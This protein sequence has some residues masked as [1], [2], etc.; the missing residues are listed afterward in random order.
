MPIRRKLE[1]AVPILLGLLSE[2]GTKG[3]NTQ[4]PPVSNTPD[5][6]ALLKQIR[7]YFENRQDLF[8]DLKRTEDKLLEN[9]TA[10]EEEIDN[11][12]YGSDGSRGEHSLSDRFKSI[13][14]DVSEFERLE[15]KKSEESPKNNESEAQ[16]MEI[17]KKWSELKVEHDI[18]NDSVLS[19]FQLSYDNIMDIDVTG[20]DGK[21]HLIPGRNIK[22]CLLCFSV[23]PPKSVI[24]KRPLIYWWLGEGLI[25]ETEDG[26]RIFGE[27]IKKGLLIAKYKPN[28]QD[29]NPIVDSCTM[30][31]W[32][33]LMLI[34]VAKRA[35]FFDFDDDTGLPANH[36]TSSRRMCLVKQ[37]LNKQT[38]PNGE[39]SRQDHTQQH[40]NSSSRAASTEH[41]LLTLFNVNEQY[42]NISNI[43]GFSEENKI[44]VLQLGRW[45]DSAKHHIEVENEDFLKALGSKKHL[46]Y[47]SLRGI[48]RITEI[49]SSLR[50]L[51]NLEILDLRA[52]H[53]LEK[54]PSDISA[55][56]KLTHLDISECHLLESMPKGLEEL[57]SLQVLKGFVVATSKRSPCKLEK[58]AVLDQLR[59]LSIY[60]RNEAYME[61]LDKLRKFSKLRIL[62][63]TWGERGAQGPK[64]QPGKQATESKPFPFPPKLE[65]LDLWCIPETDPAWLDPGELLSLR[66]LYIRGGKLVSFKESN[67]GKKWEVQILRLKYLRAFDENKPWRRNFPYLCY[68][69]I[70]KKAEDEHRASSSRSN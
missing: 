50:K 15:L 20:I 23:F 30:H 34:S 41:R 48:S 63:I 19:R 64:E 55:L 53:N 60:I 42:V 31:S 25:T 65:K 18:L 27:L 57:T 9:F 39:A 6:Y 5:H 37:R 68:L 49:P 4:D 35:Q 1:D 45:Q 44:E 59:K 17:S 24:K 7:E 14:V 32:N 26:E 33:R 22:L 10:L 69:E 51:I 70:V 66:K 52:C 56:K 54:L 38:P 28:E 16:E 2:E 13:T 8:R 11:S 36:G 62:S 12:K 61:E 58:L 21:K 46:K 40:Q 3:P 47:L 67:T 29:K 43:R